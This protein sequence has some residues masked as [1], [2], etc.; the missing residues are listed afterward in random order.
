MI[1]HSIPITLSEPLRQGFA[2]HDAAQGKTMSEAVQVAVECYADSMQD[3][4]RRDDVAY[5]RLQVPKKDRCIELNGQC[6][7]SQKEDQAMSDQSTMK[8]TIIDTDKQEARPSKP[9][10]ER[11]RVQL[12]EVRPSP[13]W[14]QQAV[15]AVCD[16]AESRALSRP[17]R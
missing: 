17:I 14:F 1:Q 13:E 5:D 9:K 12:L 10:K 7:I 16:K 8:R 2:D 15:G 3:Q 4:Q 11:E 6:A